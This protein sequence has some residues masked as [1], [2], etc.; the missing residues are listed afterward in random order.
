MMVARGAALSDHLIEWAGGPVA[1]IRRGFASAVDAAGLKGVTPHFLRHTAA[2]HMAEA[3]VS[4]DETVSGPL[5]QQ[6][7][8][9]GLCPILTPTSTQSSGCF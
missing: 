5:G 8:R 3:G 7:Y 6:D 1:S 2:V 9:L 4:M